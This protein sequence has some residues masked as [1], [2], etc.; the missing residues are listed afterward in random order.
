MNDFAL[1]RA[2]RRRWALLCAALTGFVVTALC[3]SAFVLAAKQTETAEELLFQ[4]RAA[5]LTDYLQGTGRADNA[6]LARYEAENGLCV[7]L[8]DGGRPLRFSGGWMDADTRAALCRDALLLAERAGFSLTAK[9][10]AIVRVEFTTQ[11]GGVPYQG[12]AVSW[13]SGGGWAGCLILR[14]MTA[15]YAAVRRLALRY[16][17]LG[18]AG[19]TALGLIA[20][21]LAGRAMR[22]IEQSLARQTAF[23]AAASHELRSPLAVI[24]ANAP[25][26]PESPENAHCADAIRAE[27]GR[28]GR[29]VSDLLLLAGSDAHA[30]S[31]SP[32]SVDAEALLS[33]LYA[34]YAP[35][36]AQR[37]TRLL[38]ELPEAP[39]PPLHGDAE[40]LEQLLA[41]LVQNALDYTPQ[42]GSVTLGADGAHGH[43][44]LWVSDTG[45]GVPD[46]EK[47]RV[48]E[49]FYRADHS[50]SDKLHFGLGLA[51]ARELAAL[52]GG[53]LYVR[54]A[55]G[56]GACF[57]LTLPAARR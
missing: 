21:A 9:P 20:W 36:A 24:S 41:I 13:P 3:G 6:W 44:R 7:F 51:V 34:R 53:T 23:I 2:L 1:I 4:T 29:L 30:Y 48:F 18:A 49:R 40:R 32:R 33:D 50:R 14:P 35:L 8:W 19:L 26:L 11:S 47:E 10:D 27:A 55:P 45:P 28:M 12:Q 43:V 38:A 37:G 31:L 22:P 25:Q 54:D 39:L 5:A 46:A 52:H 42:G 15:Q 17:A 57:V 16:T 56:G